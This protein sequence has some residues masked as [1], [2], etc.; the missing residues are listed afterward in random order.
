MLYFLFWRCRVGKMYN[1]IHLISALIRQFLLPNPYIHFFSNDVYADVFN[2][3]IGG[4]ILWKLSYW[5]T[6][7]G[8]R[9]GI[10]DPVSGSF[11]YLVSY[12][13]LTIIITVTGKLIADIKVFLTVFIII[14]IVSLVIVN[15][16]F[17]RDYNF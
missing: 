8:Y 9:K 12:I 13:Y 7:A 17:K 2:M 14:Y 10:D 3:F 6:G 15:R 5:L 16:I 11:G 4:V 1:L